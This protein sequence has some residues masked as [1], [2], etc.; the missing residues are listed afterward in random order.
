MS[1]IHAHPETHGTVFG[2]VTVTVDLEHADCVL[3][4]QPVKTVG[5]A[6]KRIHFHNLDEI[7]GAYATHR[8]NSRDPR[9]V[10]MAKALKYAGT[11][12][13]P[14]AGDSRND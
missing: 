11:R 12:L 3:L 13:N 1:R 8:N 14:Q 4:V 2:L 9:S 7:R 10:D 6:A 5:A